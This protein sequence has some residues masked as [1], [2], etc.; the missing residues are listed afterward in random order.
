[1]K[2]DFIKSLMLA[3]ICLSINMRANVT[4]FPW[5]EGFEDET[6]FGDWTVVH[7]EG[8]D[9][10]AWARATMYQTQPNTGDYMVRSSGSSAYERNDLVSPAIDLETGNR[11]VLKFYTYTAYPDDY[12][13]SGLVLHLDEYDPQNTANTHEIWVEN[14]PEDSWRILIIDI[15]AYAGHTVYLDFQKWSENGHGWCLDDISIEETELQYYSITGEAE[16]FFGGNVTGYGEYIEGTAVNLIAEGRNGYLFQ[17]WSDGNT[18]NPR[19]VIVSNNMTISAQFIDAYEYPEVYDVNDDQTFEEG[20][21][22]EDG[23]GAW[24]GVNF[25][26]FPNCVW[27]REENDGEIIMSHSGDY[28]LFGDALLNAYEEKAFISRPL[29]LN[30]I[31]FESRM[32]FYSMVIF[33]EDY[34]HHSVRVSTN[35]DIEALYNGGW[36]EAWVDAEPLDMEY[37]KIE[38]D[39]SE[40][41]GK[42]VYIAFYKKGEDGPG[43]CIDDIKVTAFKPE[44]VNENNAVSLN[45]FPNPAY[46][47]VNVT[48]ENLEHLEVYNAVGQLVM[49]VN[50]ADENKIDIANLESGVYFFSVIDKNGNKVVKKVVRK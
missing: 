15:S 23:F 5:N 28:L 32:T 25:T 12:V 11:Y 45:I 8:S 31:A 10:T 46:D 50:L 1:M 37:V 21:E 17:G 30:D 20:F 13:H 24:R 6:T 22:S 29:K 42:T 41:I 19:T 4:T 48:G 9:A 40:Y 7:A 43:W 26:D 33:A 35:P 27:T 47:F 34:V 2:K 49:N 3:I 39:L 36:D 38:I 16:P 14:A 44:T 18:Q